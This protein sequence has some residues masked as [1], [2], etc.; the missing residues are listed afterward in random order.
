MEFNKKEVLE[1]IAKVC[2][3]YKGTLNDHQYLQGALQ[4]LNKQLSDI[5]EETK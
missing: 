1:A 5:V 4:W 2:A 3:D